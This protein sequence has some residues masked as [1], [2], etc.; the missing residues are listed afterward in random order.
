MS[1]ANCPRCNGLFAKT[2]RDVCPACIKQEEE[3]LE[4]VQDYIKG[5]PN[6]SLKDVGEECEVE[7]SMLMKWIQE[8]RLILDLKSAGSTECEIC[9]APIL[10]RRMCVACR[11]KLGQGLGGGTP[12]GE[13]VSSD[14]EAG[15]STTSRR[16]QAAGNSAIHGKFKR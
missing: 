8:R 3:K 12:A 14:Q 4:M 6:Q 16:G 2:M 15:R 5:H 11:Q 13:P 1:L 9:G 7:E 10:G